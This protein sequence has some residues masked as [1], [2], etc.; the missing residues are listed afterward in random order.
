MDPIDSLMRT[1]LIILIVFGTLLDFICI[2]WRKVANVFLYLECLTRCV[3]MLIPNFAS[4]QYTVIGYMQML[5]MT[6]LFYY[7]DEAIQL[8][9][10]TFTFGLHLFLGILVLY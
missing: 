1:N 2:K 6:Y 8:I 4:Y 10:M 3:A 9:V 7:C 5:G